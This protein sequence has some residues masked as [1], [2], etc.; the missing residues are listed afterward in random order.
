MRKNW[1]RIVDANLNRSR[2]GL[3]VC[4]EIARFILNDAKL[5]AKFKSLRH[6]ISSSI[7]KLPGL[8]KEL[9][10]CRDSQADV[11]KAKVCVRPRRA[12]YQDVF[13][14]NIQRVKE[15]LRVLEEFSKIFDY[16]VSNNFA[17][18]RFKTYELEKKTIAK[19]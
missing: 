18:L 10:A 7:K 1:L 6:S 16:S 11:G 5:T 3:R 14:A 13:Y 9:L 2:E 12:G 17:R 19:L 8:S 15:S 4:E